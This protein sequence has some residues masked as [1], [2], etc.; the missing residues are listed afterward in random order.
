MLG[1][2]RI[3]LHSSAA[4]LPQQSAGIL[5]SVDT[6]SPTISC[7]G[8]V[9][10][11]ESRIEPLARTKDLLVHQMGQSSA[12]NIDAPLSAVTG[13]PKHYLAKPFIAKLRNN[14]IGSS[15]DAPS[16]TITAGGTH[17]ALVETSLTKV[18][19]S[20]GK[21][22]G[23][24]D[25][26][27]KRIFNR[28]ASDITTKNFSF[29]NEWHESGCPI[30]TIAGERY[31]LEILFRMLQPEELAAAQGFPKGYQFKG[32]KT[33]IIKQIGNA[34]PCNTARALVKAVL[35]QNPQI[36]IPRFNWLQDET[37]LTRA[38]IEAH[39]A[40]AA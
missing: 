33:Q 16:P 13:G 3:G 28:V 17:L 22:N 31:I 37:S 1:L 26:A 7:A 21:L 23:N 6:P 15:I 39:C 18:P 25:P 14:N 2:D 19:V 4:L 9:S 24:V 5:R 20:R 40:V 35:T 36:G 30:I 27:I 10:L 38:M 8:A 29:H 32:T 12:Q 34:V 11:S